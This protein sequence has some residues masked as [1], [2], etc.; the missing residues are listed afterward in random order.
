MLPR[1]CVKVADFARSSRRLLDLA[2][3]AGGSANTC[4]I[5]VSAD[6]DADA[7][8]APQSEEWQP[9]NM[10]GES[11]AVLTVGAGHGDGEQV[12]IDYGEAGWRGTLERWPS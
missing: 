12:F 1:G 5:R 2:N 11:A 3:H 8:A 4:S 6:A 10:T 9:E 7:D